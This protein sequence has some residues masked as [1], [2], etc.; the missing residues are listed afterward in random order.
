VT[1]T[2]DQP[3]NWPDDDFVP[4]DVLVRQQGIRPLTSVDELAAADDPFESDA[5]YDEFLVDL[6]ASRRAGLG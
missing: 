1:S 3:R 4:T 5:E 2:P 6:H